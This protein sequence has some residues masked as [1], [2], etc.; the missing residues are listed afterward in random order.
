MGVNGG[1]SIGAAAGVTAAPSNGILV[2]GNTRIGTSTSFTNSNTLFVQGT[3]H[4]DFSGTNSAVTN[5]LSAESN[6]ATNGIRYTQSNVGAIWLGYSSNGVIGVDG[7][8]INFK[9]GITSADTSTGNTRLTIKSAG[10]LGIGT[11]SPQSTLAV[12]GSAS[13]G[14]DYNTAAPT[15]GLIV[16]GSVGIATTSPAKLF[17]V[18]GQCVHHGHSRDWYHQERLWQ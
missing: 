18:G 17:S 3:G 10:N 2:S 8:D 1:V 14:T 15:N 12:S 11:T 7:N 16:E 13:V 4:F 6:T 5:V 9:T